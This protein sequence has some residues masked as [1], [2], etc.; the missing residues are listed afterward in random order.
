MPKFLPLKPKSKIWPYQNNLKNQTKIKLN[1]ETFVWKLKCNKIKIWNLSSRDCTLSWRKQSMNWFSSF[2]YAII[3]SSCISATNCNSI[4]QNLYTNNYVSSKKY[5]YHWFP[6]QCQ[7][8]INQLKNIKN[9]S[10]ENIVLYKIKNLKYCQ[11]KNKK[12]CWICTLWKYQNNIN[13][14]LINLLKNIKPKI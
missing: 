12:H 7:L 6:K 3:S 9:K 2:W 4:N 8:Y 11:I 14:I 1:F 13:C 10:I 5:D